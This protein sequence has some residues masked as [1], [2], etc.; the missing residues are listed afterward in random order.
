MPRRRE[1]LVQI[2]A[3]AKNMQQWGIVIGC[4]CLS[5]CAQY[6]CAMMLTRIL[7]PI[8]DLDI[9]LQGHLAPYLKSLQVATSSLWNITAV[10]NT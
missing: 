5:V 2:V 6:L 1:K 9:R 10:W 4:G 7:F 3:A 8:S